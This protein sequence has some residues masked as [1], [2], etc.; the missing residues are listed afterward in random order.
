MKGLVLFALERY[1][2]ALVEY[3]KAL[4]IKPSAEYYIEKACALA[5]L[6]RN[7]EAVTASNK[8]VL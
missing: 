2:D 3:D 6:G 1:D 5:Y 8:A 4:L 7:D